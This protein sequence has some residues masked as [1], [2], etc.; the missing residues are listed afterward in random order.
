MVTYMILADVESGDFQNVQ[1][2]ATNWGEITD[3]IRRFDGEIL[4]AHVVLGEHDFE[5]I[6]EAPDEE[7]ALQI[8]IAIERYGLD[9]QTH[10]LIDVERMGSLTDE[11]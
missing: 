5:F 1:E 2:W 8:A 11:I 7:A 3:E 6:Y 4:D 9:T 10:Q